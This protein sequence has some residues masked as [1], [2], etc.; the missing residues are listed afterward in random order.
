M[1]YLERRMWTLRS[2][3]EKNPNFLIYFPIR[4]P[5]RAK[6]Q[7]NYTQDLWKKIAK[8]ACK[9]FIVRHC[10]SW[11]NCNFTGLIN[12][13]A[14]NRITEISNSTITKP[15]E[16][17]DRTCVKI[18][19]SNIDLRNNLL[20]IKMKPEPVS[21]FRFKKKKSQLQCNVVAVGALHAM[22]TFQ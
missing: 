9:S 13:K 6:P 21:K 15:D 14:L 19:F 20:Q 4:W 17:T 12:V 11:K 3:L 7:N 10:I 16:M 8:N 2:N 18:Y 5:R 22:A 1:D